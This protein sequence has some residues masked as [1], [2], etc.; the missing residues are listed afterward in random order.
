M[1]RCDGITETIIIR[2]KLSLDRKRRITLELEK[3]LTRAA[4]PLGTVSRIDS[5]SSNRIIVPRCKL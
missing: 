4:R 3:K 5:D 2:E 1:L